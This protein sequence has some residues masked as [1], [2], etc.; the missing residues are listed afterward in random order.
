MGGGGNGPRDAPGGASERVGA[1]AGGGGGGFD[2]TGGG[3]GT[4]EPMGAPA[5]GRGEA[6]PPGGGALCNS[7]WAGS[8]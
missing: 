1:G 3:G 8:S 6:N 5:A 7:A 2:G 4:R